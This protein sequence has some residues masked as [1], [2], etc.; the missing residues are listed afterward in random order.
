MIFRRGEREFLLLLLSWMESSN[1]DNSI[2][3]VTVANHTIYCVTTLSFLTCD[4]IEFMFLRREKSGDLM[5]VEIA[6]KKSKNA[7]KK[8]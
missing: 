5:I 1:D 8:G 2:F 6:R 4:H 3:Y 7:S